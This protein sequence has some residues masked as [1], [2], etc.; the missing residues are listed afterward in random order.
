ASLTTTF[1][2]HSGCAN[3]GPHI[4]LAVPSDSCS[5]GA[6]GIGGGVAALI[7]SRGKDLVDRGLLPVPLTADEVKQIA[8]LSADDVFDKR[9]DY[10]AP[11]YPSQ[12]GGGQYFRYRRGD[13]R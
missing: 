4:E 13:A 10:P 12:P 11:P 3:F 2:Q 5:S 1:E 7:V 9:S 6:T 8:T